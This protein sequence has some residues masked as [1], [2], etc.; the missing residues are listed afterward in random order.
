MPHVFNNRV[1][2][3]MLQWLCVQ[4]LAVS[5]FADGCITA[6]TSYDVLEPGTRH[7]D[8]HAAINEKE[9]CV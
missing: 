6:L 5:M 3:V 7:W 4:S 9:A 8:E 2:V 1:V